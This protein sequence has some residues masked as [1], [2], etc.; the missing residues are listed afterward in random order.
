MGLECGRAQVWR[1]IPLVT[2]EVIGLLASKWNSPMFDFVGQTAKLENNFLYDTYVKLVPP[3]QRILDVFQKSLWNLGWEHIVMFGGHSRT[4]TWDG[5]DELWR[6]VENELKSYFTI[7]ANVPIM[8][9][10]SFKR[11][12]GACH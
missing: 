5:V 10:L 2:F 11:I 1:E 4:S 8:T 7:A 6:I 3:K 12:L 9:Q